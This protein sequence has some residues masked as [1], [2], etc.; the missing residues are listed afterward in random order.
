MF[1]IALELRRPAHVIF[2]QQ[3]HA[4]A[5]LRHRRGIEQRPARNDFFRL[6]DVRDEFF[7]G[8][9]S[10]GADAGERQRGA[11]QLQELSTAGRVVELRGLRRELTL[12]VLVEL[13]GISQLFEAAPIRAAFEAS[14]SGCG[15][16]RGSSCSHAGVGGVFRLSKPAC[17]ES[18][19]SVADRATRHV[20]DASH[21]VFLLQRQSPAPVGSHGASYAMLNT[22]SRGRR[23]F[24]GAR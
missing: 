12:H 17:P 15:Y 22:S 1:R 20:L 16:L 7:F 8:L 10:A 9:P 21:V 3:R 19:S 4:D 24:S 6:P 14:Q 18:S 5:A 13:L 11:H 2:R 23:N